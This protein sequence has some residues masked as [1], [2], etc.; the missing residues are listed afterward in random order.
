VSLTVH[1]Y[2]PTSG[3]GRTIV[4]GQQSPEV[5]RA[6]RPAEL[7][8]LTDVARA[9]D[10]LGFDSVLTP[11]GTWC[12]DPW[13]TTAALIAQTKRLK[14]IVAL[15]PD[16]IAPTLA[17]QMA[18][19]FSNLSG[20]RLALNLVTGSD[21]T[22][23]HRFGDWADHDARYR[24]AAEF[25]TVL[26]G[27]WSG[28]PFDF[29]GE[30]YRVAGATVGRAPF[31][32][33]S[34][35]V[36]GASDA[37]LDVAAAHADV[38]VSWAEPPAVLAERVVAASARAAAQG[39]KLAHAVRVHVIARETAR[40]AWAQADAL[41]AGMTDKAIEIA[42]GQQAA[43]TSVGQ[44]RM[45]AL[46]AGSRDNLEVAPNLW[47]GFGLVRRHAGTALVGSY[48]EVVDRLAEYDELGV[49]QVILSGQPHLEEA[50]Y[51]AEGVLPRLATRGLLTQTA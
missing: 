21:E 26:R 43:T 48:D 13:V 22:E 44:R 4:G 51:V 2:L 33:P 38:H 29:A 17:A 18:A 34:V 3:D 40:E 36:G 50:H 7:A 32:P 8:Y 45:A 49:G 6:E 31:P 47:A 41:L 10:R 24:R 5:A 39:R 23:Q 16:A 30:F 19:T 9:A 37:A 14:F 20:G 28:I 12:E 15:R 42:R 35:Y 25:L 46:H 1:W 11:V 27:A